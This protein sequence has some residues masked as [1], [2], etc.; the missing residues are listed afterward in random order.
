MDDDL[1]VMAKKHLLAAVYGASLVVVFIAYRRLHNRNRN[2]APTRDMM[3]H[4]QQVREEMMHNLITSGKCRQLIRMSENAFKTLCQKLQRDA[5]LRPTQRMTVEEQVARF[6]HI[7][8]NDLRNRF[9]SWCYR[10]SGSATSLP[11]RSTLITFTP[12]VY[13]NMVEELSLYKP[14]IKKE[15]LQNRLKTLKGN[16]AQYYDIFREEVWEALIKNKPEASKWRKK[17]MNHY[18]ELFELFAKDRAN[19]DAAE[20]AKERNNRMKN[21]E[22]RVETIDEIP[23]L[24]NQRDLKPTNVNTSKNKKRKLEEDADFTSK[25][26]IS[27]NNLA[28]AIKESNKV[29]ANSRPHVYSEGEIYNE[30]ELLGLEQDDIPP[31]Y[32]FLVNRPD[33]MR[34]LMGCPRDMRVNVLAIM[35]DTTE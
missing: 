19:A 6:L 23:T 21:N 32:L 15:N 2:N 31:A 27:F 30:L 8:G 20:T 16:F 18:D 28:D 24:R 10:R 17:P 13:A 12:H 14:D 4:R 9:A 1:H 35:M 25:I 26:M 22:Q 34:A 29:M 7:V 5:G 33:K 11:H 3:L